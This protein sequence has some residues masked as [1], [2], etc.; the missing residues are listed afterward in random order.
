MNSIFCEH[1][2]T[3]VAG[4]DNSFY[5]YLFGTSSPACCPGASPAAAS[6]AS[7]S[8]PTP[9]AGAAQVSEVD[10]QLRCY[11][12]GWF[13]EMVVTGLVSRGLLRGADDDDDVCYRLTA[14]CISFL[15]LMKSFF[16][17]SRTT[18]IQHTFYSLYFKGALHRSLFYRGMSIQ[19]IFMECVNCRY[20]V[21]SLWFYFCLWGVNQSTD[22]PLKRTEEEGH[23]SCRERQ[24]SL[25]NNLQASM[26]PALSAHDDFLLGYI[27]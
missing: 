22:R 6:P 19:N 8:A 3:F 25:Q 4:S 12:V 27:K 18:H 16:I 14:L 15:R 9:T 24:S 17:S 2:K 26:C 21:Q 13:A 10:L 23:I 11:V 1:T 20:L 7:A 5:C